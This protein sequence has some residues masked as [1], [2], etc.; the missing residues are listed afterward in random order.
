MK[1]KGTTRSKLNAK[2]L[3]RTMSPPEVRLWQA[4]REEPS[5]RRFR[6]QH[7]A[8]P[9]VLD[10]YC[11]KA[12]LAIEVDG[13]THARGDQPERDAPRDGHR[14]AAGCSIRNRSAIRVRIVS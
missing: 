9:Y 5:G 7:P 8:G 12:K 10:F 2:S 14:A 4:L 3:R 13:E 1:L 11:A 6:R